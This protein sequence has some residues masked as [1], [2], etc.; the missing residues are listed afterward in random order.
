MQYQHKLLRWMCVAIDLYPFFSKRCW[1][2][3]ITC[4]ECPG[5]NK[6]RSE[7]RPS[8]RIYST[9]FVCLCG[10]N[11]IETSFIWECLRYHGIGTFS[12]CILH[13]RNMSKVT[14]WWKETINASSYWCDAASSSMWYYLVHRAIK[15]KRSRPHVTG[16]KSVSIYKYMSVRLHE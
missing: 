8:V 5:A 9:Y 12:L 6:T 1:L 16:R 7:M 3:P 13:D 11:E 15:T 14:K 2:D 10:K 4:M